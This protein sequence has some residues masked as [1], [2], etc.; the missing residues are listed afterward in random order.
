MTFESRGLYIV[1]IYIWLPPASYV[2]FLTTLVSLEKG[3]VHVYIHIYASD[4]FKA[5]KGTWCIFLILLYQMY[6]FQ[7]CA[8]QMNHFLFKVLGEYSNSA[9]ATPMTASST[10]TTKPQPSNAIRKLI[11]GSTVDAFSSPILYS[12]VKTPSLSSASTDPSP[13]EVMSSSSTPGLSHSDQNQT[14]AINLVKS[15]RT[16]LNFDGQG[17][18]TN[19]TPQIVVPSCERVDNPSTTSAAG[20]GDYTLSDME[21]FFP[22]G[23]TEGEDG[24]EG[25]LSSSEMTEKNIIDH[26]AISDRYVLKVD[27]SET[28]KWDV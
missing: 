22:I 6:S 23:D 19:S 4:I 9:P 10:V 20:V 2:V 5:G 24:V 16:S 26:D 27:L 11:P 8:S 17:Q 18:T 25:N 7:M 3:R 21:E 15:S 14:S 1:A 28:I 13:Q 12:P